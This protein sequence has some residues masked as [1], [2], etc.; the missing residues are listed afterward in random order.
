MATDREKQ[1][2]ALRILKQQADAAVA[3]AHQA[4]LDAEA[5]IK[6]RRAAEKAAAEAAGK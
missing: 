2:E 6:A 3:R 4:V 1:R 5:E